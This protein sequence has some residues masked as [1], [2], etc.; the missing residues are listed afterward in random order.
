MA[1]RPSGQPVWRPAL[2]LLTGFE[3]CEAR[4]L[5]GSTAQAGGYSVVTIGSSMLLAAPGA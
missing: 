1:W 5:F 4:L 2:R 3:I